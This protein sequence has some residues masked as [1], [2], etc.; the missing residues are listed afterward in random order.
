LNIRIKMVMGIALVLGAAAVALLAAPIQAY[1]NGPGS[2]GMF[3]TQDQDR[4][5]FRDGDCDG[6]MSQGR[7]QTRLRIQDSDCVCNGTGNMMQYKY[8][9]REMVRS[10]MP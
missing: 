10:Q 5:R 4:L 8:Q 3:Q 6:D 9:H 7:N 1:V 2:D